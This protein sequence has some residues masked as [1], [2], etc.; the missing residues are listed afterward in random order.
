MK[1]VL[2]LLLLAGTT[3]SLCGQNFDQAQGQIQDRLEQATQEYSQLQQEINSERP[4]LAA[5]LDVLEQEVTRLRNEYQ[6]AQRVTQGLDVE[7][8][9][10]DR[11][12]SQADQANQY[13]QNTLLND[14]FNRLQ[15]SLNPAELPQYFQPINKAIQA[16]EGEDTP[17]SE[18]FKAQLKAL[19]LAFNR[20]ESLIGG[21]IYS[22]QAQ[23]RGT[24]DVLDGQFVQAGPVSYF[25]SSDGTTVGLTRAEVDNRAEIFPLPQFQQQISSVIN[26]GE[27]TLPVD[28]TGGEAVENVVQSLSLMEEF[29]AGGMTMFAILGFFIAAI[30]V[31]I[32]KLIQLMS[33]KSAKSSDL[34][35]ILD[36]L[37]NGN[38][39]AALSH[40]K[41]V[42]GPVGRM[43]TAAVENA[44]QD[45]EVIDEVL[46]EQIIATQPKLE[47][48]L[49][50]IAV[51]AA[52]A[53][54]LGLLGT[55]TGMIKT[56]KLITIVGTGDAKSLSSGISEALI[57]T[58]WGLIVAIPTLVI[59]A[60][61]SRKAKGVI[62]SMEQTA[63]GF[64]NGIVEMRTEHS[65]DR[66]A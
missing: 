48:F 49:S 2:S 44:D 23:V 65:S 63:V 34:E 41:G 33:V 10:L 8:S 35:T 42:G 9:Q 47:S 13:L 43:L 58:K 19:D 53:P 62:G 61:L 12:I 18:I 26:N 3:L 38:R 52:V 15:T 28:T 17:D 57:T 24:G 5:R 40:A 46:Y 37:R 21:K 50:F 55:V 64:V 29:E 30:I 27:G 59:H 6:N 56:F 14:F 60:L 7:T 66:T 54:L 51:T 11:Q 4:E 39:D 22:G 36:N 31:A 16:T 25:A 20:A 32:I 1:K 45:K